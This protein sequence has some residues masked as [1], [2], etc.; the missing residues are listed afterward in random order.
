[1]AALGGRGMVLRLPPSVHGKGDH[2]F[3]PRLIAIVRE[4]ELG[5]MEILL[6]S[7]FKT[8]YIIISK[9]MPNLI[10]SIINLFI[11]LLLS[12]VFLDLPVKLQAASQ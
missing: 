6:V 9:L 2:G 10:I 3:V 1:M 12:D 4:K 5:T 8:I 7:P 11:I